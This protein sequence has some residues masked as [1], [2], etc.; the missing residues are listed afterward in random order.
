MKRIDVPRG[1]L[2]LACFAL[3]VTRPVPA[4]ASAG[5]AAPIGA[6]TT[7]ASRSTEQQRVLREAIWQLERSLRERLSATEGSSTATVALTAERRAAAVGLLDTLHSDARG[8]GAP[9][10]SLLRKTAALRTLL[11]EVERRE[12]RREEAG[13]SAVLPPSAWS[14]EPPP[15]LED[16][17]GA[18]CKDAV[19]VGD[20]GVAVTVGAPRGPEVWLRYTAPKGGMAVA[21]TAGSDFDTVVELYT[22]C[23]AAGSAAPAARGDDE[24]GL[25]A[26]VAFSVAAGQTRYVRVRGWEGA[27]GEAV[28]ALTSGVAGFAGT[29]TADPTVPYAQNRQVEVWNAT[30]SFVTATNPIGDGVY[31]VAG[32]PPG[33]Y[34]ASTRRD[35]FDGILDE[36]FDDVPCPGG[37]YRGCNPTTGAPI[38]VVDGVIRTDVDFDLGRGTAMAG[39]VR[40]AVTGQPLWDMEVVVYAPNG[41]PI[42]SDRTDD[43]GRYLVSGLAAGTVY[44][45][46]GSPYSSPYRR[47]LYRDIGCHTN[48]DVTTGTPISIVAGQPTSGIDFDLERLGAIGGTVTRQLDGSPVPYVR[49]AIYD[50]LGTWRAESYSNLLGEYLT[51]GLEPGTYFAVTRSDGDYFDEIYDDLPCVYPCSPTGGTPIAVALGSTTTGIDFVLRR[52]GRIVG[53]VTDES[54]GDPL[55]YSWVYAYNASG[56]SIAYAS[57]YSGAYELR[58]P[59]GTYT[60]IAYHS[61]HQMELHQDIPCPGGPP[62]G[63][64]PTTGTAVTVAFDSPATVVDF[65]LTRLGSIAGSLTDGTTAAPIDYALVRVWTLSG[66]YVAYGYSSA[67]AYEVSGLQPGSYLVTATSDLYV[68]ELY[69]DVPCTGAPPT[70][71]PLGAGTAVAVVLGSTTSG[72]DFALQPKGSIAGTVVDAVTNDGLAGGYVL[73]YDAAGTWIGVSTVQTGGAYEVKGLATGT[74]FVVAK[75]SQYNTELYQDLSC[76]LGSCDPTTGTPV[77]VTVGVVTAGID[78]QLTPGGEI[79]GRITLS[80]GAPAPYGTLYLYDSTG[81]QL[82]Y[83]YANGEGLYEIAVEQG[84][85]F[86]VAYGGPEHVAQLYDGIDCPGSGCP[87]TSGTPVVVS[88]GA[89]TAGIDFVLKPAS[90]ITGRVVDALGNP[91]PGVAIDLWNGDGVRIDGVVTGPAGNYQATPPP[92][93]Y[94]LSTDSGMGAIEEVWNDVQCPQGP[95]FLGLCDPLTGTPV[96]VASWTSLTGGIDFTLDGVDIFV[97]S[98][99]PADDNWFAWTP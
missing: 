37:A 80:G 58:L 16:G 1:M 59:A 8:L 69:D 51:G 57:A 68:G 50:A 87:I 89:T 73:V 36:V 97:S 22:S 75:V 9:A 79:T 62:A 17:T 13:A 61:G 24:I 21:S 12:K 4:A 42:S 41:V 94:F 90:G 47:E 74:Y 27:T 76:P 49:V 91:L 72:I 10:E 96:T 92:G 43:T 70:G 52:M 31:V 25:Q 32:V 46:G 44:A 48:C 14:V 81:A 3:G 77:S 26:R 88:S 28:V 67:G 93:T 15:R 64:D 86:L 85:W 98:F 2:M 45:R 23:I 38:P 55:S 71:C 33:T 39:R 40:D 65:A 34:F 60:L 29:I 11:G 20:G 7:N 66:D 99:E 5:P 95:A 83:S 56:N 54:S 82:G 30:G 18:T 19:A 78:F 6:L 63:C 53:T 84:T 35:Y